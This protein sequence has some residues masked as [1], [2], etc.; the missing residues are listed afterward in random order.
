[1]PKHAAVMPR[2]TGPHAPTTKLA[3]LSDDIPF[4]YRMADVI[5]DDNL[6][7]P[8]VKL[9]NRVSRNA[10]DF[11]YRHQDGIAM[12][13]AFTGLVATSVALALFMR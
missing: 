5:S 11:L 8:L 13:V 10:R 3:V 12:A 1:M 4:S 9:R 7:T 6:L 2:L